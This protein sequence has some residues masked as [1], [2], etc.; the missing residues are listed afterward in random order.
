MCFAYYDYYYNM[1]VRLDLIWDTHK[2]M[3]IIR[4]R[5]LYLEQ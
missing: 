3:R 5:I 1:Y 4:C 2:D